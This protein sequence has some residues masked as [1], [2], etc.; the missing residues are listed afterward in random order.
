MFDGDISVCLLDTTDMVNVAIEYHKLSPLCAAALGRTMT[1]TTF[2]AS[3]LKNAEDRLSVTV[4]GNGAGGSIVV[5]G[6]SALN[7][8]GCIDDP[9]VD[10]PLNAQGKLDVR[11]CVGDKG[12][13]TVVKSM[14]LKE[15][16]TGSARIVSGEI[17]EDFAAYYTFSE[18]IPT[19]MA[20]GVKIGKDLKCVGAGGVVFQVMPNAKE[21][22]I[23]AAEELV[24]KFSAVSTMIE[25]NGL[26]GII[27][28]F[29]EKVEFTEYKARYKC[30]CSKE[31][32][33]GILLTLGAGELY[34]TVEKQGK[35]EVQCHFCP[36]KYVYYKKDVDEL[37]ENAKRD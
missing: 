24:S 18:Q 37:I 26:N 5:C 9:Q 23:S 30:N 29:F 17:A 16:Y 33:D 11:A 8:R 1:A 2:M 6:D 15:P 21:E 36:N 10:L 31:Y 35:I 34:D 4:S 7:M 32:V 14:G 25:K 13:I 20:L 22:S 3:S 12:R 27:D 19:A 28:G